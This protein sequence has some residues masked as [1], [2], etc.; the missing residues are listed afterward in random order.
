[1][2]ADKFNCKDTLLLPL[3]HHAKELQALKAQLQAAKA[4]AAAA[5]R[6]RRME[7]LKWC[8]Y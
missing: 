6:E 1:V 7:K 3:Q 2:I 4:K 5:K 8:V